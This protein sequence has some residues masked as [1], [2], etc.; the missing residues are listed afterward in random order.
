MKRILRITAV[1]L[2]IVVAAWLFAAMALVF[3]PQL[4]P[5]FTSGTRGACKN[6]PPSRLVQSLSRVSLV[7]PHRVCIVFNEV[8]GTTIA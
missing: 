2:G 1:D 7:V 8:R 3:A 5:R 4:S 6:G